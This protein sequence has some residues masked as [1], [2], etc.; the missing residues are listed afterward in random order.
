MAGA[1]TGYSD[2]LITTGD[3]VDGVVDHSFKGIAGFRA[4]IAADF[5]GLGGL[6]I[7]E[8]ETDGFCIGGE[9]GAGDFERAF[10][11]MF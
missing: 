1:A 2:R 10:I 4:E 3:I 5:H 6:K 8:F 11:E 9:S 7:G